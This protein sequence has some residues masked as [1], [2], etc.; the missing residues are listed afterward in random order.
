MITAIL[1]LQYPKGLKGLPIAT[2]SN[3]AALRFFK[4]TVLEDWQKKI[5]EAS[6]EG[7]AL[8]F[9]LEYQRLKTALHIFIPEE[10]SRDE[11][12]P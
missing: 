7:E 12:V 10:K 3:I 11:E 4:H 2:T 8:L 5:D 6:D 1:A 9:R